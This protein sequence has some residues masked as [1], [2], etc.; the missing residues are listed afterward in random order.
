MCLSRPT[1]KDSYEETL[2]EIRV[3]HQRV[4]DTAKVLRNDIERLS[5]GVRETP[6]THSQSHSRRCSGCCNRSHSQNHSSDRKLR[7]PSGSRQGSRVTFQEPEVEPDPEEG[8][9]NYLLQPSILDVESWLD[10]QA[11]Q[12]DMP[13]W[14]RELRAIP[15][16][17]DLQKVTQKIQ[18]SSLSSP[19]SEARSSWDRNTWHPLPQGASTKMHSSQM[20][21]PTRMYVRSPFS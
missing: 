11:Q 18:A 9:G 15:G 14:W 20:N 21:C 12:I 3:A 13:C 19:R 6:Q 4:L 10:W 8:R 1:R 7:S 16:E 2:Q 17:E 5:W